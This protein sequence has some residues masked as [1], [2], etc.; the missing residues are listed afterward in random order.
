MLLYMYII[1]LSYCIMGVQVSTI[2][3]LLSKW[4]MLPSFVFTWLYVFVLFVLI[5]VII[6]TLA[7]GLLSC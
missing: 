5:L 2:K 6:L 1:F 7:F 4:Y 3:L